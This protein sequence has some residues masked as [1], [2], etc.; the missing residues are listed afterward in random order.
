MGFEQRCSQG[1]PSALG[2][3]KRGEERGGVAM[4]E[5]GQNETAKNA[6]KPRLKTQLL[7]L[8]AE[9][10][11]ASEL[12]AQSICLSSNQGL[13]VLLYGIITRT[14][15]NTHMRHLRFLQTQHPFP[16]P[17]PCTELAFLLSVQVIWM[18]T[19][20]PSPASRT[21]TRLGLANR[22]N[23]SPDHSQSVKDGHVTQSRAI[24]TNKAQLKLF[25]FSGKEGCSI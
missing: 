11:S 8:L 13:S 22:S 17:R 9:W 10:A 21:D 24:R 5:Q 4:L 2:W 12:T 1:S 15:C 25:Y 20:Y 16:L 7:Q 23:S 3:G 19:D 6:V 14:K 18:A